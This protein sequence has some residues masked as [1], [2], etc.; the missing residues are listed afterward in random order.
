[1]KKIIVL[2]LILFAIGSTE[3]AF[4]Q[5]TKFKALFLYNFTQN[6]EWPNESI[7]P[8]EFIITVVGD[9]DMAKELQKLAEVKKVGAKSMVIKQTNQIKDISH[10]HVIFLGSNKSNLI[11]Q[12]ASQHKAEPI[13]LVSSKQ[14]LCSNGAAICFT[15]VDGKLRY[16]ISE[17]NI[18]KR[19]LEVNTKLL[20]L[21]IKVN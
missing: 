5:M 15:T 10:S 14:G 4:C 8:E 18:K 16:E 1:M 17:N 7:S 6:V 11:N 21:G 20:S 9:A 2:L 12:L 3:Q 13:L 19:N